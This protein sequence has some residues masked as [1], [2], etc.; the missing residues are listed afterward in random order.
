MIEQK[1]ETEVLNGELA[2]TK[3]A[4][5]EL[6]YPLLNNDSQQID[7]IV[8]DLNLQQEDIRYIYAVDFNGVI[9]AHTFSDGFPVELIT[10]NPVLPGENT[11]IKV[12]FADG[13]SIQDI[14]VRVLEGMD[15]K[16]HVG[17]SRTD[18]IGFIQSITTK[19]ISISIPIMLLG[20]VMS[21]YLTHRITRPINALVVGTEK[22]GGGDLDFQIDVKSQDEI[23]S[24]T[25]S[26]N[27]MTVKRKQAE[28]HIRHLNS[29]LR[30]ITNIN[31]VIIMEQDRDTLLQKACDIL[32]KARGYDAAWLGLLS[33]KN[34]FN[35]VKWSGFS[36]D[37]VLFI[38]HILGGDHPSCIKKALSLNY[39]LTIVDKTGDCE[40]CF[41]QTT[42]TGREVVITRIVYSDRFFGLLAILTTSDIAVD[43]E[44]K[45]LL[46]EVTADIAI[47]LYNIETDEAR[48]L[49]EKQIKA[50]LKEKEVLLRE[51]HHRVKNNLQVVSSLLNMQSRSV[52]D[53]GT[54]NILIESKNRINAMALIHS[55][56]YESKD[57]SEINIKMFIHKLLLELIQTF[58][59]KDT[60]ITQIVDVV[61]YPFPISIA[62]P[63][64]LIINELLT[65]AIKHAFTDRTE[66]EIKIILNTP[67][68]G[69]INLT[70]S[71]DGIGLPEGL[72]INT[73][74]TL[75]LR[76]VKILV[77][78]QLMGNI[79]I[80][81]EEGTTFII[82]FEIQ[83]SDR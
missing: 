64:G 67:A 7:A 65:N 71:D 70:I 63:I 46:K 82:E 40:D 24:L 47:A 77:E 78:D 57:L 54:A 32:I 21:L 10:A 19:I 11:A 81:S 58:Q 39:M 69:K 38:E 80:I 34:T 59:N 31:Q 22:V 23:G 25:K 14:G 62:V 61:E 17:V 8:Y 37:V 60:I 49:A 29:V 36:K 43:E 18:L 44:E 27:Q 3:Y 83:D 20:I 51:I 26:F 79:Q 52:K 48:Q 2:F 72:D 35:I 74:R 13:E 1:L 12:I 45:N 68:E 50:S 4:A 42:C 6:T 30:A 15:A 28:E 75:G 41:F 56:L 16:V 73:T 53:E 66:G 55:Q 76:L 33:D 9:I 5:E